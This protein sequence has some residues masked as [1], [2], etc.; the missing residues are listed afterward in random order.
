MAVIGA[1]RTVEFAHQVGISAN[2]PAYPSIAL[3]AAEIPMLQM[4]QSYTMFPNKG[5][6][7]E[8]V[9]LT[10]IE[11]KNGNLLHEF[12]VAQSK[13]VIGEADA[14]TMV[15]MMQGVI[16]AGTA[17]RLNSYN[18]P[19]QIAGKT[20]TTDNHTDGWFIGYTPELL[21]GTWVGCEDP[22]IPIYP[23]RGGAEMAAPKW[24]IFMSKVY[25]DK[26]LHLG[27]MKEFD[28]PAELRNDPI[29]ADT[30]FSDILNTGD[31]LTQDN[32]N[33]DAGDFLQNEENSDYKA[34][35]SPLI[36]APVKEENKD[37]KKDNKP[38][39][40]VNK[41]VDNKAILPATKPPENKT[42]PK[43]KP[44]TVNDY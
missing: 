36:K 42:V 16:A 15:K 21:A 3:G 10:R 44:K 2:I 22:F 6:N 12:P 13:Q 17:R 19:V 20:G 4:L 11:D 29:Y 40:P 37:Q 1:K 39:T 8:P 5:Y 31:T 27:K 32:G 14:F 43:P 33:G 7:T 41:A 30:R 25:A 34:I 9:F 38:V 35:D 26:S 24:G 28:Q 18:I 23:N